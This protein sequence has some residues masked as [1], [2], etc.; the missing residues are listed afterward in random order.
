M[1]GSVSLIEASD[2]DFRWLLGELPSPRGLALAP[3][4]LDTP[5]ILAM[6]R[7]LAAVVRASGREV[8]WLVAA[9]GEVVG[10][11]SFK[12]APADGAVEIGYGMAASRRGLGH[13]SAAVRALIGIAAARPDVTTLLAETST[14]NPASQ[15][16]LEKAGFARC[17]ERVDA[18]DG[19]LIL[20]RREL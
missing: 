5:E 11:I 2:D 12:A 13:A 7:R 18:E 3:G 14:T 17:G 15:R 9:G 6:L 4:G 19:P 10:M 1:T 8:A 20:W 16:V